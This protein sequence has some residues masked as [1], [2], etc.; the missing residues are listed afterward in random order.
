MGEGSLMPA[1]TFLKA[2][3]YFDK[4]KELVYRRI[5]DGATHERHPHVKRLLLERYYFRLPENVVQKI[6][7]D[8]YEEHTVRTEWKQDQNTGLKFEVYYYDVED[9]EKI[10]TETFKALSRRVARKIASGLLNID[11]LV[12]VGKPEDYPLSRFMKEASE[13][14]KVELVNEVAKLFEFAIYHKVWLP[15]SPFMMNAGRGAMDDP[16]LLLLFYKDYEDMSYEDYL[17]IANLKDPAY[18]SCYAMGTIED[19]IKSIFDML[20]YQA[21]VFRHAG[22]FG[23]NFGKLRSKYAW[24]STIKGRSS[25]PLMFMRLFNEVTYIIALHANT[26]RGANMFLIDAKHPEVLEF[27]NIKTDFEKGYQNLK[28]ANIS[29]AVKEDF[30]DTLLEGR[31]WE[32]VDPHDPTIRFRHDSRKIWANL[33][34]NATLHAEPGLLNLSAINKDNPLVDIEPITSVNPCA[35]FTGFDKSVCV[36]GSVNL[37][38]M[39]VEDDDGRISFDYEGLEAAT[40]TLHFFLT[41][42]GAANEYPLKVLTE[43]TRKYRNTG[44]GYMGLASTFVMLNQAY[45]S[46]ESFETFRKIMKNFSHSVV[47]SSMDIADLIGP[48]ADYDKNRFVMSGRKLKE[49]FKWHPD[50][51]RFEDDKVYYIWNTD[52]PDATIELPKGKKIANARMMAIAPTGSISYICQVSSGVEPIFS[53][54][55]TR[56]INPDLPSEYTVVVYDTSLEDYLK[57]YMGKSEEEIEEMINRVANFDIPEEIEENPVLVTTSQIGIPEKIAIL[58]LSNLYIDM[59]TS[60][61]FNIQRD[62]KLGEIEKLKDYDEP[63]LKRALERYMKH[64]FDVR[65]VVEKELLSDPHHMKAFLHFISMDPTLSRSVAEEFREMMFDL[66]EGLTTSSEILERIKGREEYEKAM[67]IIQTVSDFYLMSLLLNIKGTTIYVEAT[68]TPILKLKRRK[69]EEKR[70]V[71]I[72]DLGG[73]KIAMDTKTRHLVPK[74][75]PAVIPSLK[76]EVKFTINGERKKMYVELGYTEDD[77]PFEVF[78]RATTTTKE[79]AEL[80]NT[81]GRLM[82]LAMRLGV[83]VNETLRQMRKVKDWQNNYSPITRVM[84]D[85]VEELVGVLKAKG[86][87]K[88]ILINLE[89]V[90]SNWTLTPKGYYIDEEGRPR[91]PVC[92]AELVMKDGCAECH[93]CGWTACTDN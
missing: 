58:M 30:I 40:K 27:I 93:S 32:A 78:F 51:D 4:L 39:L 53:L 38:S 50:F 13:E 7:E 60:T 77:E 6:P 2:L 42:A 36:L 45:G 20:Y 5:Y 91:C 57:Y 29:V 68:R 81:A 76:K 14:E 79:Y 87:K 18:G 1:K 16:E 47:E 41:L 19:D 70:D 43:K 62:T 46:K 65:E 84:A 88:Q 21:E 25:G 24:V 73:L 72:F 54:A 75:R 15:S 85:V 17:R 23:V 69:K 44:I 37:Y 71:A 74:R 9:G 10:Y 34:Y 49:M 82:S 55:Y 86:Q 66:S 22:G 33:V 48:H 90:K 56:R 52:N 89:E 35:E 83:D 31:E 64:H 8:L 26:K 12:W 67:R 11:S 59:N 63:F 28:Y 80:F 3:G 92:G 61:T